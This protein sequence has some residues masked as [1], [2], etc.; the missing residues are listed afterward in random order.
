VEALRR[1][2]AHTMRSEFSG[3]SLPQ[4]IGVFHIFELP[5]R[6]SEKLQAH[7]RL[8]VVVHTTAPSNWCS[9]FAVSRRP[10]PRRLLSGERRDICVF[11]AAGSGQ[12]LPRVPTCSTS[13]IRLG[14][15][16]VELPGGG[17]RSRVD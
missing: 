7:R 4:K 17:A 10:R 5:K 9:L 8:N 12:Q 11:C 2:A 1:R 6:G 3:P 15:T 14:V 16:Q 13:S